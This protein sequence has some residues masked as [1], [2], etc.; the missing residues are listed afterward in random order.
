MAVK[1]RAVLPYL[2]PQLTARP[3]NTKALGALAAAAAGDA[4]ARHLHKILPALIE[5]LCDAR[6]EGREVNK[7]CQTCILI[8][9][10]L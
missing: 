8:C 1:S 9:S 2:I 3:A 5:A 7:L 4:L 10:T 6:N